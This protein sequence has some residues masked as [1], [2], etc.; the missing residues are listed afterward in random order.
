M[1]PKTDPLLESPIAMMAALITNLR[2]LLN[3]DEEAIEL[4]MTESKKGLKDHSL[5]SLI[6]AGKIKQA[7]TFVKEL[8]E[9]MKECPDMSTYLSAK[10]KRAEELRK[11]EIQINEKKNREKMLLQELGNQFLA[12]RDLE[13]QNFLMN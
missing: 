12:K 5:R 9:E 6:H 8:M 2:I 3:E 10:V 7:Y 11:K 4:Y 13:L 1:T